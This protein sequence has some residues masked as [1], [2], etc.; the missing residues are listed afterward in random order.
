LP[1]AAGA[2]A[3]AVVIRIEVEAP[4]VV[5]VVRVRKRRPVVAVRTGIVTRSL[6]AATGA[7]KED[8]P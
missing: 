4:R 3:R 2:V 7:G 1:V 6:V 5:V 8:T